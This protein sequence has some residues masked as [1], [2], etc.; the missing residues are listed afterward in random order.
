MVGAEGSAGG[1]GLAVI[2]AMKTAR[3]VVAGLMIAALSACITNERFENEG[4]PPPGDR[5]VIVHLMDDELKLAS[6][7]AAGTVSFEIENNGAR[8]H[9]FAIEG[10]DVSERIESIGPLER[11][12]LTVNL[13]PGTYTV[14]SPTGDDRADGMEATLEVTEP[15]PSDFPEDQ[16]GVGPSE[17]QDEIEDE[18][19]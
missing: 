16:G 4:R 11:E 3:L 1:R 9:G 10:P 12:V 15:P 14:Y 18:G 6:E 17:E 2:G 13:E 7:V 8:E 5:F 19:P